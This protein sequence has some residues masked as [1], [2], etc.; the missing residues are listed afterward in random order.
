FFRGERLPH[1]VMSFAEYEG[2][3]VRVLD[4]DGAL[5]LEGAISVPG[6]GGAADLASFTFNVV[7]PYDARFFRGDVDRNLAVN[8]TDVIDTL[9]ML[10]LGQQM[11]VCRDAMDTNDDGEL[12][13]ADPI[14]TLVHLFVGSR[15]L[16]YPGSRVPGFDP[17]PDLLECED[18]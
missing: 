12:D 18:F 11:P 17:T 6:S 16:P 15:E 14:L 4:A 2:F 1:D 10:F 7:G 8:L 13:I 5:V 3:G 9:N